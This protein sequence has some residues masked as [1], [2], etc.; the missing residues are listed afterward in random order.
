MPSGLL[1]LHDTG[2]S[3]FITFSCYQRRPYLATPAAR[4]LV[5]DALARTQQK[6]QFIVFG[7]VVMPE[8]VHVLL[9]ELE[10]STLAAVM[11]SWKLSVTLR[12]PLRPFWEQRYY[13][14]NVLT[15]KKRI[16]KLRYLHRNPVAR[17]LVQRPEDWAWSTF[18]HYAA[19]DRCSVRLDSRW[20]A[21]FRDQS[22]THRVRKS[23]PGAPHG[24]MKN[25]EIKSPLGQPFPPDPPRHSV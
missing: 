17:G 24:G 10:V 16:E 4:D 22:T 23:G 2:H 19:G 12:Q 8:H 9:R 13:D 6:Y 7:F 20:T 18:T 15:E 5:I 3:H 11:K 14:F 21:R 1:R 25:S